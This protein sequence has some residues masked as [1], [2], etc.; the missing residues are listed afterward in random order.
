MPE[1][2]T[3]TYL[4]NALPL[5]VFGLVSGIQME[6]GKVRIGRHFAFFLQKS[7]FS[8]KNNLYFLSS[9]FDNII[10]HKTA[11]LFDYI[12]MCLAFTMECHDNCSNSFWKEKIKSGLHVSTDGQESQPW[13]KNSFVLLSEQ[14]RIRE[15]MSNFPF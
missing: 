5:V 6:K 7:I 12:Q 11:F 10:H 13:R 8:G 2:H 9:C 4:I 15:R 3:W 14:M 1:I